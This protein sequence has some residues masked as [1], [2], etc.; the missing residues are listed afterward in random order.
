MKKYIHL[1]QNVAVKEVQRNT[2]P[3]VE[4]LSI[5]SRAHFSSFIYTHLKSCTN[6]TMLKE[7]S[8]NTEN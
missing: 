3:L 2:L 7:P 6:E 8:S 1:Q 4:L 5:F